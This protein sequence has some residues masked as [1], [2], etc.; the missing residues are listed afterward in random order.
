ME[1]APLMQ[2]VHQVFNASLLKEPVGMFA[3]LIKI[4]QLST[5]TLNVT[6]TQL[7]TP[8]LLI[9]VHM[10]EIVREAPAQMDSVSLKELNLNLN[11]QQMLTALKASCVRLLTTHVLIPALQMLNADGPHTVWES[12]ILLLKDSARYT[13]IVSQEKFAISELTQDSEDVPCHAQVTQT[14]EQ[15]RSVTS[16]PTSSANVLPRHVFI[17]VTVKEHPTACQVVANFDYY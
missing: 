4:A 1:L 15:M 10:M 9:L 2:T 11:V 8:A 5:L 3:S 16:M 14:A 7:L 17:A 6:I 13:S 12:A